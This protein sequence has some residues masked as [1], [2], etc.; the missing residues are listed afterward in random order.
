MAATVNAYIPETGGGTVSWESF[1]V[2]NTTRWGTGQYGVVF[3]VH[4]FATGVMDAVAGLSVNRFY[5]MPLVVPST[6]TFDRLGVF[7]TTAPGAGRN[8]IWGIYSNVS[9]G[10]VYPRSPLVSSP[11]TDIGAGGSFDA[12]I[13][14]TLTP[15]LYWGVT[16]FGGGAVP[17]MHSPP[18]A[19]QT[20]LLGWIKSSGVGSG[21][22]SYDT[23]YTGTLPDPFPTG[24]QA[25][26][27]QGLRIPALYGRLSAA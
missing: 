17:S 23:A 27:G 9:S 19:M 14:T 18:I 25:I 5:C 13:N 3:G 11:A 7:A 4:G 22:F 26:G 1:R 10:D 24:S 15:G 8:A 20:L 21:T 16:Q 12:T 6:I 2:A